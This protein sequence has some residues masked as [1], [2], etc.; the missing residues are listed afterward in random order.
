[1][2]LLQVDKDKCNQ[3]GICASEC[4]MTV[5]QMG[6]ESGYPELVGGDALCLA[7]GHCVVVCPQDAI[8]HAQVPLEVCPPITSQLNISEEQ[9]VQ[10]LRSRRSIRVFKQKAVEKEKLERLIRIGR[11]APTGRNAQLVEWTVFQDPQQLKQLAGM[12][13]DWMRKVEQET[14]GALPIPQIPRLIQAWEDGF[15]PILRNAPAL[16]VASAPETSR[17]GMA[18]L[19]LA[20]SYVELYAPKL[21]LGTCW[22]GFIQGALLEYAPLQAAMGIPTGHSHHF[23]VVLGYPKFKYQRLPER[24]SPTIHWH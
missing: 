1:M 9:A 5:I 16:V 21:G 24:K 15:D 18:D 4:P 23:P 10:F 8:S 6:K 7:C 3:D 2:D 17:Y 22:I 13:I 14:P 12:T 11:Y 19:S 20:L